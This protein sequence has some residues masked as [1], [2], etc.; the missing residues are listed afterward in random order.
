MFFQI[1]PQE[2][3]MRL[4]KIAALLSLTAALLM[5][6]V[7]TST[8]KAESGCHRGGTTAPSTENPPSTR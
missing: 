7:F 5:P 6:L 2:F 3:V 1:K 4:S 8:T